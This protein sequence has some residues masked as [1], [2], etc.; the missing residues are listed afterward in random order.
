MRGERVASGL[1][2]RHAGRRSADELLL[3]L[4]DET[5]ATAGAAANQREQ[6]LVGAAP[7]G[8][9][10][11]QPGRDAL[12]AHARVGRAVEHELDADGGRD[13]RPQPTDQRGLRRRAGLARQRVEEV[14]AVDQEPVGAG[15]RVAGERRHHA[16]LRVVRPAA[17]IG[18]VSLLLLVDLDG[19]VYRGAD[20]VPGVAAVLADRAARGDDVVYVT[21]NSMHYRV[22]YVAR[23]TEL[24]APVDARIGSSR[25]RVRPRST[26]ASHEAGHPSGA[27]R[28]RRRPGTGAARCG[29]GRGDRRACG[30]PDGPG[31]HRRDDRG[32]LAGCGG[33]RARPKLTYLR[34]A[35]AA[36]CIRAGARFIATNRDPVY[37]TERGLR[38]GAG[39][40]AAALEAASGV[41]RCHRQAGAAAARAAAGPRGRPADAVMIGDGILTDIAAARA[42]GARCILMLTGVSTRAAMVEAVPAGTAPRRSPRMPPSWPRPR[43]ARRLA[44]EPVRRLRSSP[45]PGPG[46]PVCGRPSKG[47]MRQPLTGGLVAERVGDAGHGRWTRA[48]RS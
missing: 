36:D 32:R 42:V 38:P 41:T 20:P 16:I 11:D 4:V 19:V 23:L 14:R 13:D 12:A 31:R 45:G 34:L 25:P 48:R 21:N 39:S 7:A 26:C 46:W 6:D 18:R 15:Q 43:G 28:G 47:G 3:S 2:V 40:I 35:A 1:I 33:R 30:D 37:P 17:T 10:D 27:G 29:A 5:R 24:G 44:A 22:D 8:V 9:A